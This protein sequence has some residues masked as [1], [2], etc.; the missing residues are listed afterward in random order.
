MRHLEPPFELKFAGSVIHIT[1]HELQ[2][3]RVFYIDFKGLRKPLVITVAFSISSG[4]FWT[5]VPQGRQ[6]EAQQIGKL[7]A[8]Y[9]RGKKK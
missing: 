4:K 5:S 3:K 8:D 2:G 6:E 1:E 7:I 9:I